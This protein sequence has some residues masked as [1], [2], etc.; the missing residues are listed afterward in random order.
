MTPDEEAEIHRW[1]DA[2]Q[3]AQPV[4][5]LALLFYERDGRIYLGR[6]N[7]VAE[8]KEFNANNLPQVME[9]ATSAIGRLFDES[10]RRGRQDAANT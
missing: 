10:N 6:G 2:V 7:T 4:G 1:F 3:S 9:L 5:T 8:A